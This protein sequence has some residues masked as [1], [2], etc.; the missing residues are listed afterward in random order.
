[1]D[2]VEHYIHIGPLGWCCF[3][4][5]DLKGVGSLKKKRLLVKNMRKFFRQKIANVSGGARVRCFASGTFLN[6]KSLV[7][8]FAYQVSRLALKDSFF[9]CG[10]ETTDAL[11]CSI[12]LG[13]LVFGQVSVLALAFL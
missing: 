13:Q 11:Q 5:A 7:A 4:H 1:M 6:R 9:G 2:G 10:V 12:H 3:L 8:F